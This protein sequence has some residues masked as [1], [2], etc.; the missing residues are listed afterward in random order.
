DA[1]GKLYTVMLRDI[2]ERQRAENALKQ[3][4][5]ELRELSANLQNVRKE[6]KTRIAR[7]LH[8]DL[9]QQLTALKMDLSVVEQ[10]LRMPGR[11]QPD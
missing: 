4:R 2:T 7:E 10:Q 11:A 1:S 5:E 6:E 8:D 3:S 9:G